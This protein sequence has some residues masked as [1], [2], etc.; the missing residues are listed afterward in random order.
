MPAPPS[1]RILAAVDALPLEPGMRVLEIGCG[2]G[3]AAREVVRRLGPD[4]FT[5]ATDRSATAVDQ[6]R[7][8][9]AAEIAAGRLD[10]R[11]VAVEDLLL[12]PDEAPYDLAFALRVGALDGR[13]PTLASRALPRV[14]AA[15]LPGGLLLVGDG[16]DLRDP[17]G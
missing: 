2:P 9:A 17:R 5:L 7:R 8:H 1:A 15:L 16:A 14:T 10:V 13:H 4:G 3:A 11:Q 6:C 12:E